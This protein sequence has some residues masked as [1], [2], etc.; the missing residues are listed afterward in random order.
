MR[1][2]IL[3]LILI[4]AVLF[5]ASVGATVASVADANGVQWTV[6]EAVNPFGGLIDIHWYNSA[7][8]SGWIA[9]NGPEGNDFYPSIALNP[10]SGHPF[11]VWSRQTETGKLALAYSSWNGLSWGAAQILHSKDGADIL[12]PEAVADS[13]GTVHIVWVTS[14]A[15]EQPAY[16]GQL[17][18]QNTFNEVAIFSDPGDLAT[19]PSIRNFEDA[20]SQIL[21]YVL[22]NQS[23]Q[24][25][26]SLGTRV[27]VRI[28][29]ADPY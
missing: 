11:V 4:L 25:S 2:L 22:I 9:A 15:T 6:E 28:H 18:A 20:N 26:P 29:D 17:T 14:T 16:Y 13:Q 7:G 12:Y 21:T 19:Y 5:P 1:K 10:V 27:R 8:A 3:S 24:G 23:G